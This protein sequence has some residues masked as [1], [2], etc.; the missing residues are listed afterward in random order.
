MARTCFL[1]GR[2]AFTYRPWSARVRLGVFSNFSLIRDPARDRR[3][4]PRKSIHD[5]CTTGAKRFS[6]LSRCFRGIIIDFRALLVL[7]LTSWREAYWRMPRR[8][9]T[10]CCASE[11]TLAGIQVRHHRRSL[12][13]LRESSFQC[14]SRWVQI[15]AALR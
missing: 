8:T 9:H 4:H 3:G 13:D 2:P 5:V 15:L 6:G 12:H 11:T 1:I 14:S 7:A 10:R